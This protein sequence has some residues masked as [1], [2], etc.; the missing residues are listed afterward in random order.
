MSSYSGIFKNIFN[1]H[2]GLPPT[3]LENFT[4]RMFLISKNYILPIKRVVM[5][6]VI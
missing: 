4:L 1:I 6:P 2:V 3:D 5:R